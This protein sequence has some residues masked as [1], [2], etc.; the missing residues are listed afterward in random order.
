MSRSRQLQTQREQ[1]QEEG[2]TLQLLGSV[3]V[4]QR[5]RGQL[6][7]PSQEQAQGQSQGKRRG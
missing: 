3:L 1:Q 7:R 5:T 2:A 6:Q 4:K